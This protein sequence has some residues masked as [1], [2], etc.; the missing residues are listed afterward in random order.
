[1]P[2]LGAC[3]PWR[4]EEERVGFAP[5]AGWQ[6]LPHLSDVH[7]FRCLRIYRPQAISSVVTFRKSSL[8][9]SIS[10]I[11]SKKEGGSHEILRH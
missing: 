3:G 8:Y 2:L 10:V 6:G 5:W 7:V 1:M 11:L 9:S 4:N